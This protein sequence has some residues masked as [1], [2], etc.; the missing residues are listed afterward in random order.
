MKTTGTESTTKDGVKIADDLKVW[1]EDDSKESIFDIGESREDKQENDNKEDEQEEENK[2]EIENS[3]TKEENEVN[4]DS[5][6]SDEENSQEDDSESDDE[7]NGNDEQGNQE[8]EEEKNNEE[9]EESDSDSNEE[10]QAKT[11]P[12]PDNIKSNLE[13][14]YPDRE[15]KSD[16]DY[17]NA[18][19]ERTE[20]LENYY[21]KGQKL[22]DKLI[23]L[24]D[25]DDLFASTLDAMFKE[26]ISLRA[27]LARYIDPADL[28]ADPDDEDYEQVQKGK[29]ERE[30]QKVEAQNKQKKF[31]ENLERSEIAI[32]TFAEEKGWKED[33]RD[34]FISEISSIVEKVANGNIDNDL[35]SKMEKAIN[36]DQAIKDAEQRGEIKG[37]NQKIAAEK[38]RETEKKGDGLPDLSGQGAPSKKNQKDVHNAHFKELAD[39]LASEHVKL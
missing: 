25:K 12:L 10:P 2:E 3:D 11:I 17:I 34:G 24:S 30:T 16:E 26:G 5:E 35:L 38:G 23:E 37:K 1:D 7:K 9:S 8:E 20:S 18:W 13:K 36:F 15:F 29:Q 33:Q 32:N 21:E 31:Q 27:A 28:L 39:E 6:N 19:N 22:N 14:A 4:E